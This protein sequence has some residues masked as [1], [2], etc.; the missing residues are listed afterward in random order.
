MNVAV[1]HLDHL[2]VNHQYHDAETLPTDNRLRAVYM[3]RLESMGLPET[4]RYAR[5]NEAPNVELFVGGKLDKEDQGSVPLDL[6]C[7]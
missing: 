2:E 4:A 1:T 6:S 3:E 7:T 5:V